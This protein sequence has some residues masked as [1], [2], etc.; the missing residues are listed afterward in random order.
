MLVLFLHVQLVTVRAPLNENSSIT[1]KVPLDS[2]PTTLSKLPTYEYYGFVLYL[3]SFVAFG[4]L[5]LVFEICL[6][7]APFLP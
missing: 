7:R 4:A 6:L 5:E 1:S 3:G 2:Q